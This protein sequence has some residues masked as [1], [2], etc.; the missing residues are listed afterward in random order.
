MDITAIIK[1]IDEFLEKRGIS[2]TNPVEANKML[3]KKG[4]LRDSKNSPGLPLR[5]LLRAKRIPHAYQTGGKYSS[6]VIPHSREVGTEAKNVVSSKISEISKGLNNVKDSGMISHLNIFN[7]IPK[8]QNSGFEGFLPVGTLRS[9]ISKIPNQ[10]GVYLIL[11]NS[12]KQPAFIEKGTG[13]FFKKIDPNVSIEELQHKWIEG[14]KVI[15]IGKAGGKGSSATLRSRIIQYLRFGD[16]E[17]VGHYG[18]RF[19][20]QINHSDRLFLCWKPM[21]IQD[22]RTEEARLIRLFMD[23]YGKRPYANLIG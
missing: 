12:D 1:A 18:G 8:L 3:E 7:S 14:S 16:G 9:N 5:N 19:I 10:K 2:S 17:S 4:L 22:P 23:E 20:W 15:Y 21:T 11:Y 6:W 13:G